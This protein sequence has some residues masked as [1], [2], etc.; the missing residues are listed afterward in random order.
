MINSDRLTIIPSDGAVYLDTHVFLNLPLHTCEIP[1]DVHALQW[2]KDS[3]HIEYVNNYKPLERINTLPK[4]A[5][6][7]VDEW[8]NAYATNPPDP[9]I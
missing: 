3:G 5:L 1:E 4:W 6:N 8:N 7:C 2:M 9:N